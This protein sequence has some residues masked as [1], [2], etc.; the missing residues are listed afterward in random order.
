MVNGRK[1]RHMSKVAEF[2]LE[3]EQNLHASTFKYF[4][5]VCINMTTPK[6]VLNLTK[7]HGFGPVF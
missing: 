5:L 4:C 1:A 6:I 2:C 7:M 3:K